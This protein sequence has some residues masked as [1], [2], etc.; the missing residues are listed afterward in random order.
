MDAIERIVKEI[1][2]TYMTGEIRPKQRLTE[3]D[4]MNHFAAGRSIVRNSLKILEER[5]LV[6][7]HPQR[8]MAVVDLS[9][10]ELADLYLLRMNMEALAAELSF[11]HLQGDATAAMTD[12]Q[13]RIKTYNLIDKKLVGLH[14]SFH[15]IV[16]R[17]AGNRFLMEEIRRLIVLAGPVRYM[18]Y[19]HPRIR[20]EVIDQHDRI[21]E[22]LHQQNRAEFIRL[23]QTHLLIS[24][25]EYFYV[26][27]PQEAQNLLCRL[28]KRILSYRFVEFFDQE[29]DPKQP[30]RTTGARLDP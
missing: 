21:L 23:H 5:G 9:A 2:Y 24:L 20:T 27:Y 22:A 3:A 19:T 16:Y 28:E 29:A 10:Q 1:Q 25:R 7:R 11:D 26:F 15:E 17:A 30:S 4:L 13:S 18:A 14:E 8:G 12:L 6:V